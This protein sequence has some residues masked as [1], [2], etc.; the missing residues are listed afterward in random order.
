MVVILAYFILSERLFWY[1]AVGLIISFLGCTMVFIGAS[2]EQDQNQLR[3]DKPQLAW[4]VLVGLP[5]IMAFGTIAM[6]KMR[7]MHESVVSSYN[8]LLL[9]I[10]MGIA[11]WLS[12]SNMQIVHQLTAL[13]WVYLTA[14]SVTV[15]MS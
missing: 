10:S 8:N 6:R 5:V 15:I 13:D 4:V 7:K 14:I 2:P 1:Q 11:I 9:G 3:D 12:D